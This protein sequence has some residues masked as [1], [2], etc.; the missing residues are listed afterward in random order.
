MALAAQLGSLASSGLL[1]STKT[2]ADLYSGIM[3]SRTVLGAIVGQFHLQDVYHTRR[4]IDA[5][6]VLDKATDIEIDPKSSIITLTVTDKSPERA[7]DLTNGFLNALQNANETMALSESSQRRLFFETQLEREKEALANAEVDLKKSQEQT[8]LILPAGQAAL[9]IDTIA[10]VKAEIAARQVELAALRD[11]ATDQNPE[12]VR[13]KSEMSDLEGQL[14]SLENG[15]AG[16]GNVPTA[17]VP[18]LALESIRKQ[19][20]VKYHETLFDILARQYEAARLD[21]SKAGPTLQ[22]LDHPKI[23]EEES[24]PSKVLIVLATTLFAGLLGLLW[25]LYRAN[26]HALRAWTSQFTNA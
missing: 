14:S 24:G 26:R 2:P 8:G 11:S 7:R 15:K 5:E 25:V 22:V 19:R 1:G 6:K 12:V 4:E 3:R 9:Q 10:K 21:E 16:G 18:E 23:P 17:Q 13:I 20:E